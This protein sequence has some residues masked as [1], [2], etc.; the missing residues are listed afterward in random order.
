MSAFPESVYESSEQDQELIKYIKARY[1]QAKKWKSYYSGDKH[2]TWMDDVKFLKGQ[3]WD[4]NRPKDKSS[5]FFN[6]A[7]AL[8]QKELPYHPLLKVVT[9]IVSFFHP[10]FHP[11]S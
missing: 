11:R 3:Q 9:I 6:I 2:K 5:I 1:E 7:W 10:I 8:I 4:A